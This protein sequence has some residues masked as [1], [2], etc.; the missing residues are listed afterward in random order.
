MRVSRPRSW[1]PTLLWLACAGLGR[2]VLAQD[3]GYAPRNQ[4]IPGPACNGL[5]GAPQN[6]AAPC[7]EAAHQEWLQDVR[8]WRDERRVR[9]GHRGTRYDAPALQWTQRSF[10]Q[11]QMMAHDRY[12]YDPIAATEAMDQL[13]ALGYVAAPGDDL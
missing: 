9:I 11:P 10:I 7:A 1:I 13:V 2:D 12:L 6:G 5:A 8:H 3:T 4:L